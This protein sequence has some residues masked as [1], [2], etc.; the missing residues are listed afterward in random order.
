MRL[1][2]TTTFLAAIAALI[3]LLTVLRVAPGV[4]PLEDSSLSGFLGILSLVATVILTPY[5]SHER[6]GSTSIGAC[7]TS[8]T[9]RTVIMHAII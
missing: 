5:F 1:S 7:S 3:L 4:D 2:R 8:L 6:L 9:C